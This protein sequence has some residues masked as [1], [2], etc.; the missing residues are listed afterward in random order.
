MFN[1]I[2]KFVKENPEEVI[3]ISTLG[4]LATAFGLGTY[5]GYKAGKISGYG[6]GYSEGYPIGVGDAMA[7]VATGNIAGID[8]GDKVFKVTVEET[9]VEALLASDPDLKYNCEFPTKVNVA[10]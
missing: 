1:R 5:W 6:I 10:Q 3:I 8:L 2:K 4:A 9:T 7:N